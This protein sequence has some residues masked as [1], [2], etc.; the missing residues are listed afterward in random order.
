MIESLILIFLLSCDKG[1]LGT[2]PKGTYEI[3][4]NILQSDPPKSLPN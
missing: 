2:P 1:W 3:A 4:Q